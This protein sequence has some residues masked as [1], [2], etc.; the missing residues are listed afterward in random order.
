MHR[1]V[2]R[3]ENRLTEAL[4]ATSHAT[5]DLT[6]IRTRRSGQYPHVEITVSPTVHKTV[7]RLQKRIEEI[8]KALHE[9]GERIDLSIVVAEEKSKPK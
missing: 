7:G 4:A 3:W 6:D 1:S 2:R 8:R 9:V 5:K